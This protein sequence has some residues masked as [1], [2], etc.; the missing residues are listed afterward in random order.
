MSTWRPDRYPNFRRC[1]ERESLLKECRDRELP[2]A[3]T[4]PEIPPGVYLQTGDPAL[5]ARAADMDRVLAELE[6]AV[7]AE[8]VHARHMRAAT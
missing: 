7:D 2:I 8:P 6:A 1:Y 3:F 5:A 4:T